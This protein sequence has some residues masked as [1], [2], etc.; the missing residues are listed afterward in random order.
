MKKNRSINEVHELQKA[1]G[2]LKERESDLFNALTEDPNFVA[3]S[4][5]GD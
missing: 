5:N 3:F 1:A 2:I 4:D